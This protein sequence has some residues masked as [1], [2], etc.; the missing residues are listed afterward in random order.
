MAGESGSTSNKAVLQLAEQVQG[1][2][3]EEEGQGS[4]P[5]LLG[6]PSNIL[7]RRT[8]QQLQKAL[9]VSNVLFRAFNI[10]VKRFISN[11]SRRL[12]QALCCLKLLACT[13]VLYTPLKECF[14]T[15]ASTRGVSLSRDLRA[16]SCGMMKP[17]LRQKRT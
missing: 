2:G 10:E 9:E 17:G 3:K 5:E 15:I 12:T 4:V 7:D 14:H 13:E 16:L 11:C 8:A 6:E 1:S